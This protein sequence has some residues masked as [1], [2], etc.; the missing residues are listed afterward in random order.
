MLD[1][2][3]TQQEVLLPAAGQR[4]GRALDDSGRRDGLSVLEL[5]ACQVEFHT[6]GQPIPPVETVLGL[7]TVDLAHYEIAAE[8]VV[9][10]QGRDVTVSP[11]RVAGLPVGLVIGRTGVGGPAGAQRLVEIEQVPRDHAA[12]ITAATDNRTTQAPLIVV[13]EPVCDIGVAAGQVSGA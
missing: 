10:D 8:D 13:Q 11:G 2:T 1:D 5:L 3:L 12:R 7:V 6:A 9:D 4:A